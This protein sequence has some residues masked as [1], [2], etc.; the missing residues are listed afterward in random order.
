MQKI[1]LILAAVA[2]IGGGVYAG[3]GK[4]FS[5][6]NDQDMPDKFVA[7]AEKRDIDFSV[8]V[9]GDVMPAT[10]L[11]IKAEVG[12]KVKKLHVLPG[13]TV[14]QGDVLAEIDDSVLLTDKDGALTEIDGAKLAME[15]A[16]KNYERSRDLFEQKLVS[17]E[18]FD[19]TTAEFQ[20][21]ENDL[22]KAQKKLQQVDDQLHFARVVAPSDGTVLTVPVVEG[23]VIIAAAS[24]NSGTTLM[25][26]ADLRKLL[27]QT[28]INQ[29]DVARIELSQPVKLRAESLKDLE[30][31]ASISFI[32]PV[33]TVT[34]NVKGFDVQALI[35]K[36]N[37]RLRPG[38]TV[39]M[40][41]PIAKADDALSVPISAVFKGE[42]NTKI[43]YVRKGETTEKR[44][45]KVGVT[46]IEH[47]QILEGVSEGEQILL[48]E[49]DKAQKRS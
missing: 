17:R 28:H 2:A 3:K 5:R 23:Q 31:E 19:N 27:V 24:V 25:T 12:G 41:V 29:V 16:K 49:P 10:Q 18:L 37:P 48:V 1:L 43:V 38:M 42:G 35:E 14:K 45:V 34:N 7:R 22:V 44:L 15:K 40:T 4:L 36:P 32:A 11:D 13:Q 33:A 46:N 9:S 8:E 30:M 26:I 47:A 6:Q 20:I 21:A 39:N